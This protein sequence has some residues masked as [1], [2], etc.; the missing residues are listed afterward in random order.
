MEVLC[1]FQSATSVLC[2]FQSAII[3]YFTVFNKYSVNFC[4]IELNKWI[5]LNWSYVNWTD[6]IELN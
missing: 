5:V 2:T 1:T 3:D 4:E 6:W